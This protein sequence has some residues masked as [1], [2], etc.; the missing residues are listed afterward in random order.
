M[1]TI[2]IE[3]VLQIEIVGCL[4]LLKFETCELA[5]DERCPSGAGTCLQQLPVW[6]KLPYNN[7]KLSGHPTLTK[8]V[9]KYLP[10]GQWG[11]LKVSAKLSFFQGS[12]IYI[13]ESA[14]SVQ[15]GINC[16]NRIRVKFKFNAISQNWKRI[17]W[18][19]H[20]WGHPAETA[21]VRHCQLFAVQHKSKRSEEEEVVWSL[22]RTWETTTWGRIWVGWKKLRIWMGGLECWSAVKEVTMSECC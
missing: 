17:Q 22:D 7:P 18:T 20:K 2:R 15:F 19:V 14:C 8:T 13:K 21:S 12:Q 4:L 3:C 10:G 16:L 1:C 9:K 5:C 11:F 6:Q